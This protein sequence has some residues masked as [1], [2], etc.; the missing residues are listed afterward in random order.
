M[1][2]HRSYRDSSRWAVYRIS[3]SDSNNSDSQAIGMHRCPSVILGFRACR[4]SA[5]PHK[6]FMPF[7]QILDALVDEF[8]RT[9]HDQDTGLVPVLAET[10]R[11]VYLSSLAQLLLDA[12]TDP[13]VG[14]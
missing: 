11:L 9:P 1:I 13:I 6:S 12:R 2:N 3:Q 14:L 7:R 4:K 8:V 10:R 5:P